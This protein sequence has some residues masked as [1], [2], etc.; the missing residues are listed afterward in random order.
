[1]TKR[2][3]HSGPPPHEGWWCADHKN[4]ADGCFPN[5]W[6]WWDGAQWSCYADSFDTAGTAEIC[7]RSE[8]RYQDEIVWSDYYPANARVPR[9]KP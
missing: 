9:V 4:T 5:S 6:R 3:W 8:S 1:M 2:K 7:A